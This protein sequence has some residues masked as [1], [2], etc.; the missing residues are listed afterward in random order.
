ML[1]VIFV[2]E[3]MSFPRDRRVRQEAAAL[4]E[5]GFRVSVICPRGVNQ[6]LAS[7]ETVDGVEV[8]RYRQLWQGSGAVTY[9]LE[10]SWALLCTAWI[11]LSIWVREGFDVLHVANPPDLFFL[12]GAPLRLFGKR[13]VYDQH[14]LSPEMFESKFSKNSFLYQF[15][16]F[17]ER[18]SYRLAD[19]VVV[20]NQSF[21]EVCLK[22]GRM[23]PTKVCIVRNGPDLATFGPVALRPELKKGFAYLAVYAGVMN[24]QDGVDRVILAL[25]HIVHARGR[26]DI[27]FALLGTGEALPSL[28]RSARELN[29]GPYIEFVGWVEDRKLLAY[30][31][32]AD[33]CLAPEPPLAMNHVSTFIKIMEYMCCGKSIVSSDLL[34]SRRS[35]GAA[36]VYVG[37]EDPAAFAEGIIG[38]LEDREDRQ[39]R[40]AVALDRVRTELHWGRSKQC[41]L[42][43]YERLLRIKPDAKMADLDKRSSLETRSSAGREPSQ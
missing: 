16:V 31:S 7:R 30:L 9:L 10:Y 35:A 11:V 27:R 41:L 21:Y 32:T 20:T 3:N 12:I 33:I 26:N 19:L 22:R 29:L 39:T 28:Q 17:A 1:K 8:Y 42:S 5:R 38:L 18:C 37:S 40:E 13:F 25:D 6:D 23:N 14:D 2:I 15:L 36:A 34:E 4:R 43:G 24:S